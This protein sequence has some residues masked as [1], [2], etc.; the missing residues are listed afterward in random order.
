M[1]MPAHPITAALSPAAASSGGALV[2]LDGRALP[3]RHTALQ[4]RAKGGVARTV[5]RQTFTNPYPDALEV[6]YQL[7]LPAD[8]AVS[9]FRFELDGVEVVGE[10]DRKHRARERYEQALVEG[11][12]AALLDQERPNL[13]TQRVGNLPPRS[14]VVCE[15]TVDQ[16]LAWLDEGAWEWRFP[17]VVGARYLGAEGR[18]ADAARLRVEASE[19]PLP[20]RLALEL[21]VADAI[22]GGHSPES[23]T[24]PTE[25]VRG[26]GAA[27]VNFR[28]GEGA[29][30]DRDVVVRWP[31]VE[32]LPGLALDVARAPDGAPDRGAAYGLLTIVPPAPAAKMKSLPRDLIFLI[33]TSGSM[34]GK[35]LAQAARVA[36][37]MI[38]T[39]T[40]RDRVEVIEFSSEPRRWK[41]SPVYA[42]EAY[43]R[44][45]VA[46]VRGLTAGGSTEM[47]AALLAA[48][49]PLR[50]GA[51]RQVVLITDGY[52]GFEREIVETVYRKLPGGCRL[53]TLGVGSSVNRALTGPAA[54]AGRGVEQVVGLDED[55][56]RAARRLVERTHAPLV[57]EL[58]VDG[59]GAAAVSPARLPDLFAAS[60][61]LISLRL[62]APG[63]AVRVRGKT[64]RGAWEQTIRVPEAA[65]A[66]A[67][68]AVRA[69]FARDRVEDHELHLAAGGDAGE[70]DRAIEALGVDYQIATRL[71]S[72]VAVS[73]ERTVDPAAKRRAETQ[74]Q[75]L[76]YGVSAEGMGLRAASGTLTLGVAAGDALDDLAEGGEMEKD[77]FFDASRSTGA[78]AAAPPPPRQGAPMITAAGRFQPSASSMGPGGAP[79]DAKPAPAKPSPAPQRA[80]REEKKVGVIAETV[81]IE[82]PSK[83]RDERVYSA[84]PP[85]ASRPSVHVPA[86][87]QDASASLPYAPRARA[88]RSPWAILVA[89]LVLA[90]LAVLVYRALAGGGA[91]S[92]AQ[93]P[94]GVTRPSPPQR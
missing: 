87:A 41:V 75:E 71:T 46:W 80:R 66:A 56:E 34:G 52:I 35:P 13:F 51:Q 4:A 30:L 92:P 93:R 12:T 29:R 89:L 21:T 39:L 9:G 84:A 10:V 45:A 36:S 79:P 72:W 90:A 76:P 2:S 23:P 5:V 94:A 31:V 7:P 61:V 54:Q 50:A 11:R 82:A 73:R 37:A 17:T 81:P 78:F 48:L 64:E 14:T 15:V 62:G 59:D 6:T 86:P 53:H 83:A 20:H 32:S 58:T 22:P 55:A 74:P 65:P 88:P 26:E 49:E 91:P 68:G 16:R 33:D 18:V 38:E 60:P 42:T 67:G 47:R 85:P 70:I 69:R 25:V 3:L 63:S 43:K 8:G 77:S 27:V 57:T 1:A 44:E 24:H 28:E 19:A 40:E